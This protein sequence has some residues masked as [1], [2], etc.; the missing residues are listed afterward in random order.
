MAARQYL[1]ALRG[2]CMVGLHVRV[3]ALP[4][5]VAVVLYRSVENSSALAPLPCASIVAARGGWVKV[6]G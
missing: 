4:G 6:V 1:L 3:P 2:A 5:N